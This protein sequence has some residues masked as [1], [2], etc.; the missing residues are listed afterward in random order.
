M[1][2]TPTN[3]TANVIEFT[4]NKGYT[5]TGLSGNVN[6]NNDSSTAEIVGFYVDDSETAIDNSNIVVP[7]RKNNTT[8]Q[9]FSLSGFSATNNIKI[10]TTSTS[11]SQINIAFTITYEEVAAEK[12]EGATDVTLTCGHNTTDDATFTVDGSESTF[13]STSGVALT[14]LA[15]NTITTVSAVT[16][17]WVKNT[18][19]NKISNA[20]ASY[21]TEFS[22]RPKKGLTFVPTSISFNAACKGTSGVSL[23]AYV[24]NGSK[25]VSLSSTVATSQTPTVFEYTI[26]NIEFTSETPF[27]FI[28]QPYSFGSGKEFGIA[29]ITIS[30]YYYGEEE[31][32]TLYTITTSVNPSNAGAIVQSPTGSALGAGS[33]VKFTANPA[34]GYKFIGWTDGDNNSLGTDNP[35]EVAS[36]NANLTLQAEFEALPSVSFTATNLAKGSVLPTVIYGEQ[37]TTTTLPQN[38]TAYVERETFQGWL[39]GDELLKAGSTFTFAE[40]TNTNL[41]ASYAENDKDIDEVLSQRTSDLS[42]VWNF[43]VSKAPVLNYQNAVGFYVLP[44]SFD[45]VT[46]DIPLKI[47]TL[48][49]AGISGKTG[50]IYN[51]GRTDNA[52]ANEGTVLTLHVQKN[53]K[54]VMVSGNGKWSTTTVNRETSYTKSSDE[55]TLTYTYTGE[56]DTAQIVIGGDCGYISSITVT[57][58]QNAYAVKI[59]DLGA[60]TFSAPIATT[61][62]QGVKAYAGV[63]SEDNATLTLQEVE[64]VIPA[65]E[66]V[67]LFG[68]EGNY[69]FSEAAEAGTKVEGN[70]LK[71]QLTAGVP[72]AEEGK[73]I[74]VLNAVNDQIG[75]YKLNDGKTLGANK[76]YLPVPVATSSD[77]A[78]E[79]APSV[80]IVFAEETGNVTGIESIAAD[81]N[82][83]APIFNL[84]GQKMQGRVAPGLYIQGGKKF[85]VK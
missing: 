27:S 44:T 11:Y 83:H 29:D 55:K 61:I 80:R 52:Q 70:A 82:S 56:Q 26:K 63:L 37:G 33:T 53:S 16:F 5:I 38:Q 15:Y 73:V 2:V 67:I 6:S 41:V 71:A 62:P 12:P 59:S 43:G 34:T 21:Q 46:Y 19:D 57:Y 13:F 60:S 31:Q 75:F 22:V 84:A 65:N 69:T 28:I 35:Y 20:N 50:K 66:P 1:R 58:P 40:K 14:G 24:T 17:K 49:N 30:G 78:A 10:K 32:E 25:T 64:T 8:G 79:A 48:A 72:A 54:I 51:V 23:N 3:G 39:N 77:D 76:A 45:G 36:L 9:A 68:E 74:C 85:L 4:V 7:I 18:T 47:N 42:L 81:V